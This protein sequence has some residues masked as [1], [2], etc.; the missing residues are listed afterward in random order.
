MPDRKAPS[1]PL[2]ASPCVSS[3][4]LPRSLRVT[5]R[6]NLSTSIHSLIS[7]RR[8]HAFVSFPPR[9]HRDLPVSYAEVDPMVFFSLCCASSHSSKRA[10][11]E[12]ETRR[13][14]VVPLLRPSSHDCRQHQRESSYSSETNEPPPPRYEDVANSVPIGSVPVVVVDEKDGNV[15]QVVEVG[16]QRTTL[17]EGHYRI[18]T[19]S[20]LDDTRVSCAVQYTGSDRSSIISIPSTQVTGL[21]SSYTGT[22]TLRGDVTG[23]TS[24]DDGFRSERLSETGT[25]NEQIDSRP[26]S[27]YASSLQRRSPSPGSG[28]EGEGSAWRHPVMRQGWLEHLRGSGPETEWRR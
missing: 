10:E 1:T 20:T 27:Y 16:T 5:E 24:G 21:G 12:A 19:H 22:T 13:A 28:S 15:L 23:R 6:Y 17:E 7:I 9:P 26:P 25:L 3:S 14:R 2:H 4:Q 11:A 8:H 18:Q